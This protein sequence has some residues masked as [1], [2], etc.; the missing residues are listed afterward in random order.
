MASP[1]PLTRTLLADALG[2]E[3]TI[4]FRPGAMVI[5]IDERNLVAEKRNRVAGPAP[6]ALGQQADEAARK[7]QAYG[8]HA[9]K[10]FRANDATRPTV[11]LIHGLN[12]SSAGFVHVVPLA[13]SG[14]LR[15][16]GLRLPVQPAPGRVVRGVHA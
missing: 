9:L 1:A 15:H 12:S 8:M 11:C 6:E 13:R 2:P 10:S 4:A 5:A 3:V 16:R 7:R 14:G